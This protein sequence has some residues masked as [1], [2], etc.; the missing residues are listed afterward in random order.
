MTKT[1]VQAADGLWEVK[2][3]APLDQ[4]LDQAVPISLTDQGPMVAE[5]V[6]ALGFGGG[7][8]SGSK[9]PSE[10]IPPDSNLSTESTIGDLHYYLWHN[11]D[12]TME[13]QSPEALE[14]SGLL[15]EVWI[16]QL[17][18]MDRFPEESGAYLYFEGSSQVL[19]GLPLYLIFIGLVGVFF[20]GSYFAGERSL[21]FKKRAW[22]GALPHFL[23]LWLPLI[24]SV[25]LMYLF[26]EIGIMEK[27][28]LYPATTKDPAMLNPRWQ[29]V[30]LYLVG[31]AVFLYI[32]RWLVRKY[33]GDSVTIEWKEIRSLAFLVI[34]LVG[35]YILIA[36]PF[37]LLFL[38]PVLF[39]FFIRGRK[40]FGRMLDIFFF[41]LGGL[42]LYALIYFF[43]WQILRYGWV[44]LWMFMNIISIG[45]FSFPAMLAGTAVVGA[46]LSMIVNTPKT[47]T[48]N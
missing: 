40:G 18:S 11:P 4:A 29:A 30:I 22:L 46:G 26:V 34:G 16:R 39:W 47:R 36:N 48:K 28:H 41:V 33:A 23:G 9:L 42:M 10:W 5:G 13:Y 14:Q 3:K 8:P 12:D 31:T 44:F 45:M 43:G 37:S 6:P 19:R 15:S 2:I 7:Y 32:G 24:A 1:A 27:Y 17:L 20:A 25:V 38:V 21:A 35:I